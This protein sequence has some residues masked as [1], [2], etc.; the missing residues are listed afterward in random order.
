MLLRPEIQKS[1]PLFI[2]PFEKIFLVVF[3]GEFLEHLQIFLFERLLR[4]V[5]FLILNIF[6]HRVNL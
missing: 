3:Y 4:M 6:R 1:I 5:F 2:N